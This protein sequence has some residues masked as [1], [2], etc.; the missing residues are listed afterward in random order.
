MSTAACTLEPLLPLCPSQLALGGV[1]PEERPVR[2][3]ESP[4]FVRDVARV[5]F[6]C[7]HARMLTLPI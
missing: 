5:R 2:G 6:S 1:F 7:S 4:L 3:D